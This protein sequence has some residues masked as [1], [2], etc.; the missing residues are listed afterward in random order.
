M[1]KRWFTY[2]VLVL[3]MLVGATSTFTPVQAANSV[4]SLGLASG[5]CSA[6]SL[7]ISITLDVAAAREA[8]RVTNLSGSVLSSFEH[9]SLAGTSYAGSYG[10]GSWATQPNGT[11]IGL[12]GYIGQTPPSA[13]D[14]VEFFLA[15]NCG[16][17]NVVYTCQGAYGTCPQSAADIPITVFGPVIPSGFVLRTI[18]CDVDVFNTAAG[19]PTTAR[20]LAGQSWF[21][22][23]TAVQAT[24]NGFDS[25]TE[26]FV[27]GPSNGFIPTIC[28]GGYP[29]DA[30]AGGL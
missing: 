13:S 17:G 25:W 15:Y 29:P 19:S 14:T 4:S 1:A 30:P 27:G 8:G 10:F 5:T 6:G 22:N 3:L 11:I 7:S 23:P 21:V 28:V 12:Y 16:T 26:V 24:G 9:A 2:V 20:V 18:T